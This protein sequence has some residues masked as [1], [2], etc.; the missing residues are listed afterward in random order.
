MKSS[1]R[2]SEL[3]LAPNRS[4]LTGAG[5]GQATR[6]DWCVGLQL[7][8]GLP[9]SFHGLFPKTRCWGNERTQQQA[10]TLSETSGE[11]TLLLSLPRQLLLISEVLRLG[12]TTA[13][14]DLTLVILP[15]H[16]FPECQPLTEHRS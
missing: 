6:G 13:H 5:L 7:T 8:Q 12:L 16:P 15:P 3:D 9:P 4:S 2:G 10:L 1:K 11:D 14:A